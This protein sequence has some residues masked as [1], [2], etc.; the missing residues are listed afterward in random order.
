MADQRQCL[1]LMRLYSQAIYDLKT[2]KLASLAFKRNPG[3]SELMELPRGIMIYPTEFQ[4]AMN[5]YNK[6]FPLILQSL[7]MIRITICHF[8]RLDTN[9]IW[10]PSL[11]INSSHTQNGIS[12]AAC[13]APNR[14]STESEIKLSYHTGSRER[15]CI[16]ILD[17]IQHKIQT[18]IVNIGSRFCKI[19]SWNL[20]KNSGSII[21]DLFYIYSHE[22]TVIKNDF[23]SLY[24]HTCKVF[25]NQ[26]TRLTGLGKFTYIFIFT[27]KKL[28]T[29]YLQCI[30]INKP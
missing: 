7:K 3:D 23:H 30:F 13:S 27:K 17:I 11:S 28:V 20:H 24:L 5:F 8:T 15:K 18:G 21:I 10:V 25:N 9:H 22:T 12:L 14:F 19:L 16:C 2:F 29:Q 26:N 6:M 4:P 1:T